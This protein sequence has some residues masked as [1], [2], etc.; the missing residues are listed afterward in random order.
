MS[1][2]KAKHTTEKAAR[3]DA[4]KCGDH[5]TQ[6]VESNGSFYV[7]SDDDVSMVRNWERTVFRGD[8]KDA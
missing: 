1:A 6:I 5:Y 2:M 7:E 4:R 3:A 8:G